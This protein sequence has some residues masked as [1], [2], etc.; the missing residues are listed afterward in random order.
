LAGIGVDDYVRRFRDR[1]PRKLKGSEYLDRFGPLEESGTTIE[2]NATYRVRSRTEHH[3]YEHDRSCRF[4]E[5]VRS[6]R[7][8]DEAGL[9]GA[10]EVMFASHWSYGQRCGLGCAEADTLVT[11]LR[12][13][14][15]GQG[16]YG[17]K[18]SGRGCGGMICVLMRDDRTAR[19]ALESCVDEYRRST[20]RT[21][22]IHSGTRPGTLVG[23]VAAG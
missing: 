21:A 3:I 15:A 23:G 19:S 8:G 14:G 22:T 17:A 4:V 12:A 20:K 5:L 7:G 9:I 18:V 13:R 11:L 16:I 2:P 6:A 1:L 10:G